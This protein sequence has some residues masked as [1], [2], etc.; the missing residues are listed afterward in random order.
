MASAKIVFRTDK[1]NKNGEC[2]VHIRIIKYRKIRYVSTGIMIHKS[3]WDIENNCVKTKVKGSSRLNAFINSK[4]SDTQS[5]IANLEKM[6]RSVTSKSIKE[7]IIGSEPENFIKY[8]KDVIQEPLREGKVGSYNMYLGIISKLEAYVGRSDI[9]FDDITPNFLRKYEIYLREELKNST[10]TIHNNLKFFRKI[11][12]HAFRHSVISYEKN[13]FLKYKL[14]R[15]KTERTYL[16]EEEL[17]AFENVKTTPGTRLELH[18]DMFVFSAYAGGI[19]ISDLL[20]MRWKNYDGE[21]LMLKVKKTS[22]TLS[23]KLPGKAKQ[24]LEKYKEESQ[25]PEECIFPILNKEYHKLEAEI[26][27][28]AISSTEAYIN[29][30][31]KI[32][33]EKAEINKSLSFHAS[34]HTW[35]TRALRKGMRIEHVS[36]LMAHSDIK[37]T[38]IYS[39][40][41]NKELDDAM[42]V[43]DD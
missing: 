12:N 35:A 13:P 21:R 10:N 3:K 41:V 9:Y 16:T 8:A 7:K 31:I 32:I 15:E 33:A 24:I 1:E 17:V 26:L 34:R 25:D 23:I 36:K 20:L 38:Q 18:K 30:N 39:H 2:P 37:T 27:F 5:E 22:D 19:R 6:E 28:K 42:G 11:F 43:F 14:K 40:I 29:K 4:L